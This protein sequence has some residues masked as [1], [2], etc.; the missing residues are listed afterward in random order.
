MSQILISISEARTKYFGGNISRAK[1]Y[2]L[3]RRPDFPIVRIG[4]RKLIPL[5]QLE[6]WIDDQV[7]KGSQEGD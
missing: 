5:P 2:E 6:A 7:K 4:R 3:A 1:I